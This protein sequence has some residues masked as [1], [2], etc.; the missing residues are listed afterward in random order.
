MKFNKIGLGVLGLSMLFCGAVFGA[1]RSDTITNRTLNTDIIFFD[2]YTAGALVT[3]YSFLGSTTANG[4]TS[5][6]SAGAVYVG[7]LYD[8]KDF[9]LSI[10]PGSATCTVDIFG[11]FGTKTVGAGTNTAGVVLLNS[12]SYAGVGTRSTSVVSITSHPEMVAVRLNVLTG[13]VTFS[14]GMTSISER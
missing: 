12:T 6:F 10:T 4:G 8:N 14:C 5:T 3:P 13:T 9:A 7:D 11:V 2:E 1:T